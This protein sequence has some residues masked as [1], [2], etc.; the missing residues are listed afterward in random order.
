M[1]LREK[2]FEN[3]V[4]RFLAD[5]GCWYLKTW[6]NGTQRQ[7]VPDLLICCNGYFIGC[8]L[9]GEGG[10]PS[11]LQLWNVRKINE[12]NGFAMVLYPS[13][14]DRFKRFVWGLKEDNFTRIDFEDV[15]W[16]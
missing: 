8:E 16:T 12:S 11:D 15:I 13:A 10:T 6:S 9:K 2:E 7:G 4:K 5:E 1:R 3:K 14:F